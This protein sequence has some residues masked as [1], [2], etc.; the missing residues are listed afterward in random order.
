MSLFCGN[1]ILADTAVRQVSREGR[2]DF[3]VMTHDFSEVTRG[4]KL[5][6][7]FEF[8]NTGAGPLSIQGVHSTCGCTVAD[9]DTTKVYQPGERGKIT[10]AL[11]T[12]N[13]KGSVSKSVT[14]MTTAK[15]L[16][17]RSLTVKATVKEEIYADPP[18]VDFGEVHVTA[19]A[20]AS[21]KIRTIKNSKVSAVGLRY[22]ETKLEASL[23][24][25]ADHQVLK[26]RIKAGQK[27][28]FLKE[29]IYVKTTS[30]M[31]QELPVPVRAD[32][33]GSF[34]Y[35]P[36][37]IEFGAV[38][39]EQQIEKAID[40]TSDGAYKILNAKKQLNVNGFQI[41]NVDELLS[42]E[43]VSDG[44]RLVVKLKNT[45]SRTGSVHGRLVF[46]TSDPAQKEFMVDFYAFFQEKK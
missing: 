22:D 5:E 10:V 30:N 20:E 34:T 31:L 12:T 27:A 40:I 25:H 42:V 33:L 37:Y 28:G 11:D 44:K 43:P 16:P 35:S 23:E 14:V 19:M 13:F 3:A 9:I 8:E 1:A 32:L 41:E 46:E 17:T 36:N 7:S 21:T 4:K 6:Y 38:A 15:L 26:I 2:A 24:P 45:V 39:P 29:T 18:L